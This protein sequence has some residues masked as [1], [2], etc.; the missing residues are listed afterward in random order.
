MTNLRKLFLFSAFVASL[1]GSFGTDKPQNSFQ[2]LSDIHNLSMTEKNDQMSVKINFLLEAVE[3]QNNEIERLKNQLQKQTIPPGTIFAFAGTEL[4][5]G[6]LLCN[7]QLVSQALYPNLFKEVGHKFFDAS[8]HEKPGENF[9]YLPDFKGRTLVGEDLA[10]KTL[11]KSNKLG[12]YGGAENTHIEK[13]QM[14]EH[15]HS[16]NFH[17][18]TVNVANANTPYFSTVIGM[19]TRREE[20]TSAGG[21]NPLS[22]MQPYSVVNWMIKY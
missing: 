14:P 5:P 13:D 18:N 17:Y 11:S 8:E 12:N 16:T 22:L 20:S 9:F 19:G 2:K 21:K 10:G 6:Y 15:S 1:S 4:P 7:G 3:K